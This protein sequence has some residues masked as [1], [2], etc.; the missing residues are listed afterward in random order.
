MKFDMKIISL[1]I[2]FILGISIV[3]FAAERQI[4]G[5]HGENSIACIDCHGTNSPENKASAKSCIQCH[6]DMKDA[7]ESTFKAGPTK[8]ITINV[9][10]AHPGTL[11]CTLCHSVHD[12]SQLYCNKACHH[13][14]E[15]KVP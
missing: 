5:K 7:A 2:V 13:T 11:R 10:N 15:I 12:E 8:T 6:G 9:H 1:L 4:K 14:F 3:A